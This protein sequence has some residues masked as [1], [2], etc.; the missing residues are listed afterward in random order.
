MKKYT[1]EELFSVEKDSN[2]NINMI[3]SNIKCI[4]EITSEIA[5]KIQ[6]RIDETERENIEIALRKFYWF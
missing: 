1:Y 2:N 5:I 3:K 6:N 4:N